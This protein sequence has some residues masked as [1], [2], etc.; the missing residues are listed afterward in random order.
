MRIFPVLPALLLLH[1]LLGA[2]NPLERP[3]DGVE[4]RYATSQPVVQYV[5]HV[6]STD[7]SG[8]QVEM[9]LSAL[10]DTFTLAMVRHPEEDDRYWRFVK[11]LRVETASGPGTVTRLDDGVWRVV[12]PGGR[13]IVRYRMQ[14]P[15]PQPLRAAWRPF[16][17]RDG[18]LVGGPQSLLYIVGATLAPA[19]VT[20]DL[21]A[22]WDAATGLEPTSDP[23]TY[24]APTVGVLV[25]SPILIGT[26]SDRHFFVDGVPHRIVYWSLAGTPPFDTLALTRGIEAMARQAIAIF[27]R[28]PYREYTFLLQDNAYGALEHLNSLTLGAPSADL[29][30]DPTELL[31]EIAHEYFHTWNLLRIRPAEWGDVTYRAPRQPAELWVSEGITM[32]YADLLLR[33]AGLPVEDSTRADHFARMMERYLA[34]RD[35]YTKYTAEQV[36]RTAN[37]VP[38]ALGDYL[39][40]THLH[41]ELLGTMLDWKVRT[42]TRGRRSLDDVMRKMMEQFSGAPGFSDHDVEAVTEAVCSCKLAAFFAAYVHGHRPIPFDDYLRMIGMRSEVS[43]APARDDSGQQRPDLRVT[44]WMPPGAQHPALV[45]VTPES[46]WGAAGLHTGDRVLRLDGAPIADA[47]A[48]R[49]AVRKLKVGQPAQLAIERGGQTLGIRVV[50]RGYDVPSVALVPIQKTTARERA[51]AEAWMAGTP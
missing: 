45:L 27:G 39:L 25:D 24:F 32:Y 11:D 40:S 4:V 20:L 33:R 35:G 8:F 38:G 29:A 37:E 10:P 9:R 43:W 30:K 48:F 2:Q 41:G 16:L 50:I 28:A 12:A 49:A 1:T 5:I 7:L 42:A 46:V 6:D 36:S 26:F 15:P 13:A 17:A 3:T 47:V 18:G 19:I 51:L 31:E 23:R 44:A 21:P 14:L 34:Q 22:G